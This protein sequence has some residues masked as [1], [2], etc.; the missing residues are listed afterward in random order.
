MTTPQQLNQLDS[1]R[2]A[3]YR[4][5]LKFY[6]GDQWLNTPYSQTTVSA[7]W[8]ETEHE[9]RYPWL[10]RL[11]LNYAKV[12]IDKLTSYVMTG[13][14]YAV[15]PTDSTAE[16]RDLA[17]RAEDALARVYDKNYLTGLD[18]DTEIDTAILGD[19]CYKV[20]WDPATKDVRITAPDVQG[21]YAW[22]V[23]DDPS[24]L[25]K[26]ASKYVLTAEEAAMLHP[27]WKDD[28][29]KASVVVIEVWTD[30][31]FDLWIDG[32]LVQSLRNPY[33]FIPY[34]IFPNIRE[35][36]QFW[37]ASDLPAL[38]QP[39]RELNRAMSQLSRILELSGNPIAVLEGVDRADD[40]TVEPGQIWE[41]PEKSKAYLLDLLQGG[42]VQLHIDYINQIYRTIH[43]L[44]E[45]PRT[46][47]GDN[48]KA[49]SGIA[50]EMELHPLLQKVRRKRLVRTV[51]YERRNQMIL[52]LLTQFREG[53]V[54]GSLPADA[55]LTKIR[56]RIVWGDVLPQDRGRAV[57]DEGQLVSQGIHSR[58]RA[59]DNLGVD[60]PEAE[61]DRWL[62]EHRRI[63]STS[64]ARDPSAPSNPSDAK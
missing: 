5:L 11:T 20:T 45:A 6:Q 36:K 42:G 19:G 17:R 13:F 37:G 61:F 9:P 32:N 7:P 4:T 2:F 52:R 63:Q 25:W 59:A 64:G 10:R 31:L 35:P 34:I 14:K 30:K 49:L 53:R 27:S 44:S 48:Q 40:I 54:P 8:I 46:S 33:G 47:F 26:V 60:N 55:D 1:D 51:A 43:D 56:G 3:R 15:D 41:L 21:L 23:G 16:A 22:W 38:I 57:A 58:K 50:L 39:T 18:F 12:L 62:E 29:T 24:R 28:T